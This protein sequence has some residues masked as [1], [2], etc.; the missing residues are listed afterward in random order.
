MISVSGISK[1]FGPQPLFERVSLQLDSGKCFGLVGANGSG[2][3]T[4]LKMLSGEEPA[5][6]GIIGRAKNSRLGTLRQDRFLNDEQ[7]VLDVAMQGDVEVYAALKREQELENGADVDKIGE[8][9]DFILAH[10]GY[11]LEARASEILVGLGIPSASLQKPLGTLSGGYKLR[12]LLAQV[13]VGRP[14]ILLLDEPTNHLDILS[15]RWLEKFLSGFSGLAVVI[16]HDH[17]FLNN[18]ASH[19]LDVDYETITPYT[20]NYDD[21]LQQKALA[22]AQK[23]AEIA[24]QEKIIAEK[25]AFVDRFRAKATKARQAQS[26]AKQIERIQ[27]E[28]LPT[29]SRQEPKLLFTQ[30]RPS[31]RDVLRVERLCKAYGEK[32]VLKDVSLSIRRGERVSVIGANGLGK[33]TLLKVLTSRTGTDAGVVEW[34]HEVQVGYFPQDHREILT[35]PKMTPLEFVW[36]ACPRE[37]ESYVRGQLGRALFSGDDVK[38]PIGALSGGEAA[39][40]IFARLAVEHPNVLLLDEPTNHLDLEAIEA[41]VKALR[42]FEGTVLFVSHDRWFVEGLAERIIELKAD[43]FND[44]PGTYLEYLASSGD[45]HL[46]AQAVALKAKREREPAVVAEDKKLSWEERKRLGNR[47]K[48]L[49]K[50]RDQ[51]LSE[52]EALEARKAAL[53]H[54]FCDPAFFTQKSTVEIQRLHVEATELKQ[55]I[56]AKVAEWEVLEQELAELGEE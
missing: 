15:I 52:I 45:D 23:E 10:D 44:Y 18:I 55:K 51:A 50:L 47:R 48:T 1:V 38:K 2:K 54:D 6:D 42:N 16:S 22:F 21:F 20:G 37:V 5:T 26:R 17:R 24:R 41:L 13:L 36:E 3:S 30:K 9:H 29:S 31:G 46:D 25:Q 56:E 32:V 7:T 35:D 27:V 11:T 8:L 4:F 12:V 28:R 40:L 39:R 53:E 14:D 43:G 19:I 33:S 49:P 34:G